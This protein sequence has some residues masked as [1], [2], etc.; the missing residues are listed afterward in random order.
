M[1]RD[2]RKL[3]NVLLR[4]IFLNNHSVVFNDSWYSHPSTKSSPHS[5]PHR[6]VKVTGTPALLHAI[7][8]QGKFVKTKR[9]RH[10]NDLTI[11]LLALILPIVEISSGSTS[12][13]NKFLAFMRVLVIK[14][15]W[16][17]STALYLVW[18]HGRLKTMRSFDVNFDVPVGLRHTMFA[19]LVT[20]LK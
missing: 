10:C 7:R 15:T 13:I 6:V 4:L 1:W 5:Y 2:W 8:H 19:S 9:V 3:A 18:S 17:V 12:A 20:L 11:F 14:N 16:K